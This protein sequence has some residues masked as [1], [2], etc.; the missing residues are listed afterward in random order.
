MTGAQVLRPEP[1]VDSEHTTAVLDRTVHG[2]RAQ[3]PDIAIE[4]TNIISMTIWYLTLSA[5]NCM[6]VRSLSPRGEGSRPGTVTGTIG[7]RFY[8]VSAVYVDLLLL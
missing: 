6:E 4:G 5:C 7:M 8:H 3:T 2:N 1:D